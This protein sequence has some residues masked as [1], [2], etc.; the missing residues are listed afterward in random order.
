MKLQN[1]LVLP[2][3]FLGSMFLISDYFKTQA[4]RGF[5]PAMVQFLT[6]GR[7]DH[8][9]GWYRAFLHTT[10]LPHAALFATL[11]MLGELYAGIGLL[12]GITTRLA[13]GVAIF[14]LANF[15]CAKESLPWNPSSV[16]AADIV[17]SLVILIGAAGRAFGVDRYIHDRYP[18]FLLS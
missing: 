12:F 1:L 10:V 18:H 15:M 13:A 9:F 17:I 6:Q 16:D 5:A 11:V 3:M 8:G 7:G 4:P 2:R 14:L